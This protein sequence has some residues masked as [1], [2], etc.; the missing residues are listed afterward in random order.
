MRKGTHPIYIESSL[1]AY[2]QKSKTAVQNL[3]L[4]CIIS[5]LGTP[6]SPKRLRLQLLLRGSKKP[7]HLGFAGRT[8]CDCPS[9]PAI[10]GILST[11]S[12]NHDQF[13][14]LTTVHAMYNLNRNWQKQQPEQTRFRKPCNSAP[15]TATSLKSY[16]CS[17]N[18]AAMLVFSS[19]M[20]NSQKQYKPLKLKEKKQLTCNY[21]RSFEI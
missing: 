2:E 17:L 16:L 5:N 7:S 9:I 3:V 21:R 20:V 18:L 19:L 11:H 14:Q 1:H 15:H 12:N 8:F 6:Y 13:L 4:P 10:F